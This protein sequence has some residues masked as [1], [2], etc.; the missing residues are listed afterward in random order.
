MNLNKKNR[1]PERIEKNPKKSQKP[2]KPKLTEDEFIGG[3]NREENNEVEEDNHDIEIGD[4]D[5]D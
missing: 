2:F 3:D 4:S 1:V 5:K